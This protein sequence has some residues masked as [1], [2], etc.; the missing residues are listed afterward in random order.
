MK[1]ALQVVIEKQ[2]EI[3]QRDGL[4]PFLQ[5]VCQMYRIT[6][7]EFASIFGISKAHAE[8]IIK[9]RKFPALDL[10]LRIARYFDCTVEELFGWRIDDDG[11]RRPL[12][13]ENPRT[14]QTYRLSDNKKQDATIT[15]MENRLKGTETADKL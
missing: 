4:P 10:A 12:I 13:I 15:L 3:Y 11:K 8:Q 5:Q 7:R 2:R 6:I 9:Q 1:T 14:G